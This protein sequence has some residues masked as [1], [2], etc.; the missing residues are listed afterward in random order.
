MDVL[1]EAI[2]V[3]NATITAT[4]VKAIIDLMT[5]SER[6]GFVFLIAT[7]TDG[8]GTKVRQLSNIPPPGVF[9][10]LSA[11]VQAAF[12]GGGQPQE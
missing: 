7:P 8:G 12:D 11:G 5:E 2:S 3:A 6:Y 1:D 10:M 9:W 4:E